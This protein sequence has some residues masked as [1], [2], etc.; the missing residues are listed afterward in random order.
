MNLSNTGSMETIERGLSFSGE[1]GNPTAAKQRSIGGKGKGGAEG[2]LEESVAGWTG[3]RT[4]EISKAMMSASC[5]GLVSYTFY[6]HRIHEQNQLKEKLQFTV[7]WFCCFW[8]I[9]EKAEHSVRKRI[10]E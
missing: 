10:V 3:S 2:W 4:Q 6:G 5:H 8:A 1:G 9:C 7:T